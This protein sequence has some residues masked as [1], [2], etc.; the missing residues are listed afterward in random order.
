MNNLETEFKF[1]IDK[2]P[3]VNFDKAKKHYIKQIYFNGRNKTSILKNYFPDVD[4]D[5]ISTYR[6]RYIDDLIIL[7]VKSKTIENGF[8][9]IEEEKEITDIDVKKLISDTDSNIIIKNRYIDIY[10]G[11]KFEFDEYLNLG[12]K[13]YTVE[14]EVDKDVHYEECVSKLDELIRDHYQVEC[15]DVTFDPAYK[16]SNL[17]K[18]FG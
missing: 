9:R 14:I 2:L 12:T 5:L 10:S 15:L 13:L 4:F 1:K 17:H 16:N 8:S 11:Y 3:V 7:T 6:I 18:N